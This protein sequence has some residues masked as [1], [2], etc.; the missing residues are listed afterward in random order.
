MTNI[1]TGQVSSSD[2]AS[3][4]IFGKT[5]FRISAVTP[6]IVTEGFLNF[7]DSFQSNAGVVF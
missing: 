4:L 3:K 1:T 2:N 5:W 7:P 6:A